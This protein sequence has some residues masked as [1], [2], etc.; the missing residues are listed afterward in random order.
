METFSASL[1]ICAGNSPVTGEFPTQRP[2]TRSFDVFFDLPLNDRLDKQSW[3]WWFETPS[4]PLWRNGNGCGFNSSP[5]VTNPGPGWRYSTSYCH[6]Y[7][8][9]QREPQPE[10]SRVHSGGIQCL[11][12]RGHASWIHG[13]L[14]QRQG[15]WHGGEW[16]H[17]VACNKMYGDYMSSLICLNEFSLTNTP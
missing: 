16:W 15:W 8:G 1:A 12:P 10:R 2:V 14:G 5:S 6:R 13:V 3:G 4:R 9:N 7:G 11:H 17:G